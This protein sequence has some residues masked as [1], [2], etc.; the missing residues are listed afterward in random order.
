MPCAAIDT[1][2]VDYVLA[3]ESIAQKIQEIAQGFKAPNGKA[4]VSVASQ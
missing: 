1:R 3:L 2:F 4:A